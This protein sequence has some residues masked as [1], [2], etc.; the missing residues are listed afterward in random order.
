MTLF[1][2]PQFPQFQATFTITILHS[3]SEHMSHSFQ[4]TQKMKFLAINFLVYNNC[5]FMITQPA[6]SFEFLFEAP[7]I[8]DLPRS[9]FNYTVG[10]AGVRHN[11]FCQMGV[12]VLLSYS[13]ATSPLLVATASIANGTLTITP[14]LSS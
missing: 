8:S 6:S 14:L 12:K 11:D 3:T 2:I 7:K 9:I 5:D 10:C 4:L 1:K 13:S